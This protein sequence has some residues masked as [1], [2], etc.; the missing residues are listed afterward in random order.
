[1]EENYGPRYGW[2]GGPRHFPFF[3]LVLIPLGIGFVMGMKR[4]SYLHGGMHQRPEW[5]NGVPPF[6]AEMHRRAHEAEKEET[7]PAVEA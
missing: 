1:M 4:A 7:K 2:G 6:F 5:K 3:P